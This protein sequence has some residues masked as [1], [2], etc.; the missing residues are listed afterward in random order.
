MPSLSSDLV[1][2]PS[3]TASSPPPALTVPE[4]L[5]LFGI[6]LLLLLLLAPFLHPLGPIGLV[7]AQLSL[8]AAPPLAFAC[9]RR[10]PAVLGIAWPR[11][12]VALGAALVG[13][14]FW[15]LVAILILPWAQHLARPDEL[16]S[17]R[18]ALS[19][20]SSL[21]VKLLVYALTPAV[22]EELLFR[23]A[24]ARAFA[25]RHGTSLAVVLSAV[26]FGA[27]HLSAARFFPTAALGIVLALVALRS[28]SV[29]P[30]IIIH[31][32][33]NAAA[34]V[35]A[36]GGPEPSES[37]SVSPLPDLLL[38]LAAA[39]VTAVGLL[40]ALGARA[41]SPPNRAR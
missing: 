24:L 37:V 21:A 10:T 4:A 26:A 38:A 15:I 32:L 40:L 23:G 16:E 12:R 14:S 1:T 36:G 22:C 2:P 41:A 19:G 20:E 7:V 9:I 11:P 39:A 25:A 33:N 3:P 17:L 6:S 13:A 29:V 30:A 28:G 5:G 8:I 27:F 31:A 35:L 34:V 18:T